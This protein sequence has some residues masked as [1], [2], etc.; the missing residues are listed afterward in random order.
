MTVNRYQTGKEVYGSKYMVQIFKK[1]NKLL[2]KKFTLGKW[3]L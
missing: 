1:E 2:Y 3:I